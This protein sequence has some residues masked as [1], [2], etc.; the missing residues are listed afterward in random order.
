MSA[1]IFHDTDYALRDRRLFEIVEA[2]YGRREKVLIFAA[3]EERASVID[4]TLW[5]LKQDAFIPHK[6][7]SHLEADSEV[8]VGIVA[9]EINP[10]GASV[11]ISDG[12]CSLEFAAGFE[13]IHEF[14]DR[15]SPDRHEACRSRFR[16]YR[17]RQIPVSYSK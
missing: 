8:P 9:A 10:S 15:S 16:A 2:A 3:T 6:V 1:C 17:A 12:H 4:R 14:V 11:L 13:S 7:I 5:V